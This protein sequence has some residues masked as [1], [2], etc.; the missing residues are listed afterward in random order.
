MKQPSKSSLIVLASLMI[1]IMILLL[2]YK[3]NSKPTT[4]IS[5]PTAIVQTS[6]WHTFTGA[7]FTFEYPESWQP[8]QEN[9]LLDKTVVNITDGREISLDLPTKLEI[10]YGYFFSEVKN[11]HLTLEEIKA[12]YFPLPENLSAYKRGE[13]VGYRYLRAL[14]E[15]ISQ[16][17]ILLGDD[18]TSTK[19]LFL[20]YRNDKA[21][22]N[23]DAG[24][25]EHLL[26]T[27]TYLLASPTSNPTP[28]IGLTASPTP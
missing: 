18:L 15:G 22:G 4:Q 25:L 27:F 19:V 28:T 9:V 23:Q 2:L 17:S 5:T 16:T 24:Y 11:R 20:V 21:R 26:A 3:S 14:P 10:T 1:L 12:I 6:L 8:P 13:Q 7:A